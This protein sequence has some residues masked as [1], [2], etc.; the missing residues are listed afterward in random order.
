MQAQTS[1]VIMASAFL[2]GGAVMEK[3]SARM[4]PMKLMPSA[5]SLRG[6]THGTTNIHTLVDEE[7]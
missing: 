3:Q 4:V 1:P 7:W 5:V 6:Q 2:E